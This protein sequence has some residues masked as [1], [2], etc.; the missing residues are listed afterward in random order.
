MDIELIM[1]PEIGLTNQF[2]NKFT[3]FFGFTPAVWHSGVSKNKEII[4]SGIISVELK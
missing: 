2:E 3:E 4:W 1:L